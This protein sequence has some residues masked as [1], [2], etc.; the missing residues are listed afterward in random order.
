MEDCKLLVRAHYLWFLSSITCFTCSLVLAQS[1]TAQHPDNP[2]WYRHVRTVDPARPPDSLRQENITDEEVRE[3]QQAALAVY[4]DSIVSISGVT[5]GCGCEEGSE[6]TA[7]VWL[8]L[9]RE[10]RSRSLVLSKVE[11]HWKV[12]AVQSWWLRYTAH[13]SAYPGFGRGPKQI[14]W[15]EE[16]QTLLGSFPACPIP[17]VN[18]MFVRND[19]YVDISSIRVSGAIRRVNFK[20][21]HLTPVKKYPWPS[22]TFSID[23]IA[24]DC[25]DHRERTDW[26]DDYY[27]DGSARK[28]P[29]YTD[30]VLWNP[31]RPKTISA[32]D[33][34]L[35]CGARLDGH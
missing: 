5:D 32:E 30:A 17:A 33:L 22:V 13:W 10:D 7:Q 28:S 19:T 29:G 31:I 6:C 24:F 11:G 34:E 3:V 25:L 15:A 1:T 18:W 21:V 23:T 26:I 4:P 16:E 14:A 2:E 27:D 35:I 9:Y 20:Y 12:G 8:A